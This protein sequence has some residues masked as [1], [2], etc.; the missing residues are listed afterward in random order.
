MSKRISQSELESMK[1][2]QKASRLKP[3]RINAARRKMGLPPLG[4]LKPGVP[5]Y[6]PHAR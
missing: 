4:T 2:R 1:E 5:Q 6:V 3:S